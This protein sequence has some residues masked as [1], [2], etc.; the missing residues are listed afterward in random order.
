MKKRGGKENISE[1]MVSHLDKL[2]E[3]IPGMLNQPF[4]FSQKEDHIRWNELEDLDMN[5]LQE[6]N[7]LDTLERLLSHA[8][9]AKIRKGDIDR[10]GDP[11]MIKLI[12]L[13]QLSMEYMQFTQNTIENL[14]EG[15]DVKYQ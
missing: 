2:K 11:A 4:Q 6:N 14:I 8:T 3:Q 13:S 12:K 15:V 1:N 10:I 9:Y 7:D 5:K